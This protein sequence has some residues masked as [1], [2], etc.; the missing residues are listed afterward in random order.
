F[1]SASAD[2]RAEADREG[3]QTGQQ[4]RP[5]VDEVCRSPAVELKHEEC[6]A[7]EP[8]HDES[9]RETDR[10][11]L[12]VRHDLSSYSGPV[13]TCREQVHPEHQSVSTKG[14]LMRGRAG[15]GVRLS[16]DVSVQILG[17]ARGRLAS[18]RKI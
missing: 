8:E 15:G 6:Q 9:A 7:L 14:I 17:A 1:D 18:P 2:H 3:T 12:E 4:Q 5:A 13:K 11:R 10:Q 16:R